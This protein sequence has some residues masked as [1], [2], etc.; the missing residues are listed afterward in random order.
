MV[1]KFELSGAENKLL[2][3]TVSTKKDDAINLRNKT[4]RNIDNAA[5]QMPNKIKSTAIES[6]DSTS[7]ASNLIP[8]S[9]A[10]RPRSQDNQIIK[11][12]LE[13]QIAT[14]ETETTP[15]PQL[16][17]LDSDIRIFQIYF[18]SWQ[19]ELL[20][21]YFASLDNSGSNSELLEFDVFLRLFSSNYIK[22]AKLWGALSWRFSEKTGLT[23]Q[24][25]L[26][27]I[28]ENP[29]F[30]VYF[31]NPTPDN[32]A[33]YHNMWLQGE[34]SHPQFLDV[35]RAVF[36]ACELPLDTLVS[37]E[38]VENSSVAN[39][40]IGTSEFWQRY[41]SWVQ[42][43]LTTANRKLPSEIRDLMH[44]TMADNRGLHGG[45]SYVPF[46]IERLFPLFMKLHADQLKGFK[47]PAL[48]REK[49]LDVHLKLLRE[50][51]ILSYNTKSLWLA[52]CWVNY[53]NLYLTQVRGREW[54]Q[55][56]LGSITPS[57]IKF[58]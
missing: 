25:L 33:L 17:S 47:I 9:A 48:E 55:K 36:N 52:A 40:F 20:D 4:K 50:M 46:I 13:K 58:D 6:L 54:C 11:V 34:A 28:D 10:R 37:I 45:A 38:A 39:F 19:K 30:D 15:P 2:L 8:K 49:E 32:E 41:L 35:V 43:I 51:K 1:K 5:R 57:E 27:V 23:G 12:P 21:P 14:I 26:S 7:V 29:G 16:G 18:E 3:D 53:R 56:Y 24:Q 31:C 44:S 42:N 22:G